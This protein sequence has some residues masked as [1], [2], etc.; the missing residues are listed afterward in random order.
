M[1]F[2]SQVFTQASGSIGGQTFSHNKGGLYTRARTVP[3][4]PATAQQQAVRNAMSQLAARWV[5]T[6]TN[7]QR[8]DWL[9]YSQNV[10][11]IGPLG[12]PREVGALPMYQRSNV[13]RL[14][15]GLAVVDDAPT[16]FDLGDFT[17]PTMTASA[18]GNTI[19]VTF[20]DSDAWA[21]E[22]DSALLVYASNAQ[23][24]SINFFKG[25]YRLKS[26]I[27]GDSVTPP[28]TP[29]VVP[30]SY[31]L[32]AGQRVFAQFRATRA[33]GRLSSVQRLSALA[34]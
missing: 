3:V 17:T 29:A 16:T 22:D 31:S 20:D 13:S 6:L 1:L 24:A 15:A 11:L 18:I 19:S 34:V 7:L 32:T 30:L 14:Q 5:S 21:N 8:A 28:T 12:D 23:N 10:P 9:T 4:N 2:K 27:D 33:D 25:P 26:S